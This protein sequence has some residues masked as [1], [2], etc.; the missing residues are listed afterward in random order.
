M[1]HKMREV[2]YIRQGL[3]ILQSTY[4]LAQFSKNVDNIASF[5]EPIKT[6]YLDFSQPVNWFVI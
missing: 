6:Y 5:V 4:C 3:L 2:L 1:H